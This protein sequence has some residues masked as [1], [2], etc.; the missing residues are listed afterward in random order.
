MA[1]RFREA[2]SLALILDYDGTLVALAPRP[3]LAP[4]DADLLTLLADLAARPGTAVVHLT[5]GRRQE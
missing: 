1:P 3:D 5:S 4:P 2:P